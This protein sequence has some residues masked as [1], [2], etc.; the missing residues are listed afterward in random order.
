MVINELNNKKS[1][2]IVKATQLRN[3]LDTVKEEIHSIDERIKQL[4]K[5]NTI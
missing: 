1:K 4:Q 3:D 5:R 2:L